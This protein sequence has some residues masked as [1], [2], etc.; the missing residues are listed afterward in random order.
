MHFKQLRTRSGIR[1]GIVVIKRDD[2]ILAKKSQSCRFV[3]S[4]IKPAGAMTFIFRQRQRIMIKGFA[5]TAEVKAAVVSDDCLADDEGGD[6]MPYG[7]E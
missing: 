2:V 1:Q 5:Q 4:F 3:L 7:V 6:L